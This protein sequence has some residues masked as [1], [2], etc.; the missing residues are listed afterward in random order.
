MLDLDDGIG[1]MF[2]VFRRTSELQS[3]CVVPHPRSSLL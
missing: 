2:Q 1:C 3:A